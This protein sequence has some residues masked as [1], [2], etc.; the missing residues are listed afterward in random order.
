MG[1]HLVRARGLCA[2]VIDRVVWRQGHPSIGAIEWGC[3]R[4]RRL[5]LVAATG[6][7]KGRV[8]LSG[9]LGASL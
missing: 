3:G 5:Q 8:S 9:L 1:P 7:G 4:E 6:W 2:S